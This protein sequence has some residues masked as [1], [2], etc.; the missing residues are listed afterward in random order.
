MSK[1]NKIGSIIILLL[2]SHATYAQ[3]V[4]LTHKDSLNLV[5]EK[6]YALNLTIFKADSQV[7]DI[8]KLFSLF[9]DDFTY[10]HPKYGGTYSRQDLYDGY[11]R[12]QKSGGFNE[13]IINIKILDKIIGLNAVAVNKRFISRKEGETK[14][15]DE[16]MTLFEFK[17]GKISKIFE[18]W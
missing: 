1:L 12:N 6:Y 14:E 9:T 7:T 8:D 18:Y 11:A 3:Q 17:D 4:G 5:I 2:L 16:E 10:I 15:G 13:S